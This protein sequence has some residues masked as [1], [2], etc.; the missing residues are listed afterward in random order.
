MTGQPRSAPGGSKPDHRRRLTGS[1][2]PWRAAVQRRQR[3]AVLAGANCLGVER[4]EP[5]VATGEIRVCGRASS[6]TPRRCPSASLRMP[7][8]APQIDVLV[9]V[10]DPHALVLPAH[11]RPRR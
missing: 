2:L 11:S 6:S 5:V 4:A 8:A 9:D 7:C 10:L 1:R 3:L